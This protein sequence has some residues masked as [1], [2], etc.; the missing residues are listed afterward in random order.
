MP[1]DLAPMSTTTW[2]AVSF[3]TVP[4]ITMSS[5]AASSLSVVK[6]SRA[7]AKSSLA[8]EVLSS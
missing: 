4:L 8:L 5:P 6:L 1:S 2:V 3:S 7:A